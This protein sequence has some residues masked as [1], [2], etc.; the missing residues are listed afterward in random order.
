LTIT[1]LANQSGTTTIFVTVSALVNG[2]SQTMSDGFA[3][4]VNAV[5]DP[6]VAAAVTVPP[7]LQDSGAHA[8]TLTATDVDSANLTFA[9]VTPPTKGTLGPIGAVSCTGSP[10]TCTATVSYTPAA[11]ATGPDSFT[12]RAN[13]G[14]SDSMP[15]TVGLTITGTTPS[16]TLQ[17]ANVS[18]PSTYFATFEAAATGCSPGVQWQVSTNA[19]GSW[20]DIAGAVSTTYSFIT[21]MSDSGK[22]FR[23]VFTNSVNSVTSNAAVLT[24]TAPPPPDRADFTGDGK[25]DIVWQHPDTGAVLLWEMNGPVYVSSILL[26]AG[27]TSWKIVGVGD[28]TGDGKPDLLWQHPATGAVLLW[29][30]NGTAFVG[31]SFVTSGGTLWKVVAVADFT[32]D[33]KPDI[34]WQHPN[35]GAVLLWEMNGPTYVSSTLLNAGGTAW[36]IVGAGDMTGDGKADLIWQLPSTGAVLLWQMNGTV[37]GSGAFISTGGTLWKLVANGDFTGDGKL[38]L[39]WQHPDTGAVLLWQMHDAAYEASILVGGGGTLWK[40]AG[41]R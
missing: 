5:N 16:I 13:D 8:I 28:F 34:V 10:A 40:V 14:T 18:V 38:D 15:A 3:L 22:W 6:P 24:V 36:T 2:T 20:S 4:T 11:C 33:G 23:A 29:Q 35:T 31:G 9:I 39:L 1:P 19:G 26:N 27:G 21:A 17:P 37:L 32:G 41:P 12:Y 30:M 7:F 25:P